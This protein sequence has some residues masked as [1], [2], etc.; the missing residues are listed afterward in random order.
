MQDTN[1]ITTHRDLAELLKMVI[2]NLI[3]SDCAVDLSIPE[4][5][6]ARCLDSLGPLY[7]G[8]IDA[9]QSVFNFHET[10]VVV[11]QQ[12]PTEPKPISFEPVR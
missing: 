11:S 1:E 8:D 2:E 7:L 4:E 3:L 10:G 6:L 9:A 5:P 12:I